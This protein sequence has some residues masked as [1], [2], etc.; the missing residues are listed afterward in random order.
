MVFGIKNSDTPF[1]GEVTGRLKGS[2]IDGKIHGELLFFGENG[3]LI[4]RN[5]FL[6]GVEHGEQFFYHENGELMHKETWEY[7]E[8][9][10]I[11]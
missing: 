1:T 10:K 11:E 8:L 5:N 6:N 7:G 3:Q 9:L 4:F 2:F